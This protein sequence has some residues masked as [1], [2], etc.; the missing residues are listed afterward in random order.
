VVKEVTA[1]E[2]E[3]VLFIDEIHT[4]LLVL[5]VRVPWMQQY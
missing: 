4:R 2:G 5:A 1:A 3:A